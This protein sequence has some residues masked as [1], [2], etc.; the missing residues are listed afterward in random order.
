MFQAGAFMDFAFQTVGTGSNDNGLLGGI[1]TPPYGYHSPH[2]K[3]QESIAKQKSELQKVG[4][5]LKEVERK[6]L[7][8]EQ[9]RIAAEQTKK[10]AATKRLLQAEQDLF[11][12][13]NR[14]LAVRAGIIQRI[15][16]DEAILIILM[17][18]RRRL[19]VA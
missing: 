2:K 14:L 5:V 12:E 19:R 10:I 6:R 13:I 17:M 18:K 3:L 9:S 7:V 4:S 16:E 8:A 11:E 1:M 15:R